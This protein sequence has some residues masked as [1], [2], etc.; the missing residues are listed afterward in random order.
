MPSRLPSLASP[1]LIWL[2]ALALSAA[3]V[4][5]LILSGAVVGPGWW[6][7][8]LDAFGVGFTIGGL[9]DVLLIMTITSNMAATDQRRKE[10]N[11]RAQEVLR[12]QQDH[13][14][15]ARQ[16]AEL[17]ERSRG[18]MDKQLYDQV[19]ELVWRVPEYQDAIRKAIGLRPG[20]FGEPHRGDAP[21]P[22]PTGQ[23]SGPADTGS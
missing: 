12:P 2:A 1:R 8:T 14:A 13:F 7:G 18:E 23:S 9:V 3:G 22:S 17:L 16:A 20:V 6:Q 15:Q 5:C 19:W 21:T 11:R 4:L 10:N